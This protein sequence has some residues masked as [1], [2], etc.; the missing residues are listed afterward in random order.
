MLAYEM[1]YEPV[2]EK[3]YAVKQTRYVCQD[4]VW[5]KTVDVTTK[6]GKAVDQNTRKELRLVDGGYVCEDGVWYRRVGVK[7]A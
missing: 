5:Y 7:V 2:Q 1:D 6:D 4:G 3:E